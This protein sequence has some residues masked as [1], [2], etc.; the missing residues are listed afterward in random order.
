[1][2]L[3]S[4]KYNLV[5]RQRTFKFRGVKLWGNLTN[6]I[7]ESL[8]IDSFKSKFKTKLTSDRYDCE[9]FALDLPHFYQ[10]YMTF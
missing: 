3:Y 5:N 2:S 1:M 8:T 4:P 6:N 7:K 10:E 9:K